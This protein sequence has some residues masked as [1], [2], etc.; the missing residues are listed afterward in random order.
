MR[1]C[2]RLRDGSNEHRLAHAVRDPLG[3]MMTLPVVYSLFYLADSTLFPMSNQ[4]LACR[5]PG[6]QRLLLKVSLSGLLF[7]R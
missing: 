3:A 5:V 6:V 2:G 4:T 1:V 7:W